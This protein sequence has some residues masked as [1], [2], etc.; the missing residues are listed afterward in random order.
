VQ[1]DF[2]I[3]SIYIPNCYFLAW[4]QQNLWQFNIPPLV[5]GFFLSD[6][7]LFRV[8]RMLTL[9]SRIFLNS[10]SETVYESLFARDC[11]S[12]TR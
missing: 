2:N 11:E 10:R 12:D 7:I 3:V 1:T 6:A 8:G 5:L 4:S 9:S